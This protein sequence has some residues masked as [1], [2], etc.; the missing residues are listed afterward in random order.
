MLWFVIERYMHCLTGVTYV[1]DE[2]DDDAPS[3][4]Y[5]TF[6]PTLFNMN[7]RELRGLGAILDFL[8]GL[9]DLKKKCVPK[10]LMEPDVLFQTFKVAQQLM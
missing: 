5:K 6:Q 1:R 8:T 9:S 4:P 7:T 10:E 3:K 2:D